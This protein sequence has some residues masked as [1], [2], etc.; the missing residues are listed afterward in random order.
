MSQEQDEE[1]YIFDKTSGELVRHPRQHR[2][3]PVKAVLT[4]GCLLLVAISGFF[5][6]RESEAAK[7]SGVSEFK[8]NNAGN[9]L[10]ASFSLINT[11][12]EIVAADG[13]AELY[14]SS[15][16]GDVVYSER[17]SF[18]NRGF[19]R[20]SKGWVYSWS[21]PKTKLS[22]KISEGEPTTEAVQRGYA[23]LRVLVNGKTTYDTSTCWA[24][25]NSIEEAEN[26]V[27][28]MYR[29]SVLGKLVQW[30]KENRYSI[31]EFG[32]WGWPLDLAVMDITVI[33]KNAWAV[34]YLPGIGGYGHILHTSD[35]GNTWEIQWKSSTYGPDPFEVE[36]LNET[37]GWVAANK[38]L[39]H[40]T[41][42]GT[43][44]NAIWSKTQF[45]AYL[46]AFQFIDRENLQIGLSRG[47]ILYTSD[48][49]KTW[50]A[51]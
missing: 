27:E 30:L 3:F 15:A 4:I 46:R 24:T 42:E 50:Q 51:R 22:W 39:L 48:G 31:S 40:T 7:V 5:S 11:K 35:G 13:T 20:S 38:V 37:E 32:N 47:Q 12:N 23:T 2:R 33:G 25:F 36:F 34:G 21:I 9:Y 45:G 44:W 41:D 1:L 26:I 49:G 8:I 29:N 6:W 10:G 43:N 16:K 28:G 17:F 18:S 14:L 19:T